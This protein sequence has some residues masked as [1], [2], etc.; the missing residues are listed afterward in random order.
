M[1]DIGDKRHLNMEQTI[2]ELEQAIVPLVDE[3]SDISFKA[4]EDLRNWLIEQITDLIDRNFEQLLRILYLIDVDEMKVRRLI[5]E[6]EGK[7]AP[8]VI[9]DLIL[10]R[11]ATKIRSRKK[12]IPK[13]G[14]YFEDM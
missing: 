1:L 7:D 9:A 3:D 5:A 2:E 11:Q 13:D 4:Y 14:K 12:Y 10:E 6:N 8:S